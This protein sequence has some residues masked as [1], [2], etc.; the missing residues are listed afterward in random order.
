[1]CAILNNLAQCVYNTAWG[2]INHM[3]ETTP[4]CNTMHAM[5]II[6]LEYLQKLTMEHSLTRIKV[7]R[8]ITRDIEWKIL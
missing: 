2:T 3:D 7:D 4:Y 8:T 5:P 6:H 1:M